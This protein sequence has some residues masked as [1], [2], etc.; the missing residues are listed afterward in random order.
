MAERAHPKDPGNANEFKLFYARDNLRKYVETGMVTVGKYTY[1]NPTII[2][3][4]SKLVIG[5]YCSIGAEGTIFLGHGHDPARVT[6]Y[7]FCQVSQPWQKPMDWDA[8]HIPGHP[9]TRGDVVIGSDVWLGYRFTVMS[10]VTIGHGAIV[11]SGAIV[12]KD[13]PPYAIVGGAPATHIRYRF[14]NEMIRDLLRI[15]WWDWDEEKIR[16][17]MPLLLSHDIGAFIERY[18]PGKVSAPDVATSSTNGIQVGEDKKIIRP[19]NRT[20]GFET[21]RHDITNACNIRCKFCFNTWSEKA[22][23]MSRETYERMIHALP[24]FSHFMFSCRY[25]PSIHPRFIEMV[26]MI[27]AEHRRKVQIT[28]NLA[29]RYTD[30]TIKVLLSSGIG[31]FNLSVETFDRET[32]INLCGADRLQKVLANLKN[33]SGSMRYCNNGTALRYTT[34]ALRSNLGELPAIARLCSHSFGA[35]FHQFRTPYLNQYI[36]DH[37]EWFERE[38]LT[39]AELEAVMKK[40]MAQSDKLLFDFSLTLEQYREAKKRYSEA[41]SEAIP[42][43]LDDMDSRR[44]GVLQIESSGLISVF[45]SNDII[46]INPLSN[47][48][49]Y[50]LVKRGELLL[51]EFGGGYWEIH[52]DELAGCTRSDKQFVIES[53]C[54]DNA[55]ALHIVGWVRHLEKDMQ[56]NKCGVILHNGGRSYVY[57]IKWKSQSPEERSA[58]GSMKR[59]TSCIDVRDL[60]PG[61]YDLGLLLQYEEASG[62][63]YVNC[64]QCLHIV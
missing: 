54:I 44:Y 13:V 8:L 34:M 21:V 59:F 25:E 64:R 17:A 39:K 7:P 30:D 41:K 38:L 52:S 9:T 29:K 22:H 62:S 58:K 50:L 47:P 19:T 36:F 10:G 51:E 3:N 63:I 20:I 35:S 6:T 12:T 40:C 26:N 48:G 1:G 23:F 31:V 15:A 60:T 53:V 56:R 33:I 24:A 42:E 11:A 37:G 16:N 14:D 5:N 2:G 45:G 28:T 32:Y 61:I 27:P 18:K 46:D 4:L 43:S 49:D 57:D 55:I